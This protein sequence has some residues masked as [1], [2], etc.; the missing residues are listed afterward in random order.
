VDLKK[1]GL[2]LK[3]DTLNSPSAFLVKRKFV[4]RIRLAVCFVSLVICTVCGSRKWGLARGDVIFVL[5][6][7]IF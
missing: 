4:L 7:V 6:G 1:N 3:W 5:E 2:C